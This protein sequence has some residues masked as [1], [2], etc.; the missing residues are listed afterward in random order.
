MAV[1]LLCL[2]M[3][4][5]Q[6]ASL[7]GSGEGRQRAGEGE[8]SLGSLLTRALILLDQVPT[9]MSS[10]N[11][12][13]FLNGSISLQVT[14]LIYKFGGRHKHSVHNSGVNISIIILQERN[15]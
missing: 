8:V 3:A 7:E 13:Y 5:P 2:H 1:S 12:H 4:F 10:F 6:Y 14:T 9:F 11:L 15:L